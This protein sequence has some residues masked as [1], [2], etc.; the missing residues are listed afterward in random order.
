MPVRTI[1]HVI[2]VAQA[3]NGGVI[4]QAHRIIRL[5][6]Y[7]AIGCC[8]SAAA[9]RPA[10]APRNRTAIAVPART[11]NQIIAVA[12]RGALAVAHLITCVAADE[13]IGVRDD[14]ADP[15]AAVAPGHRPAITV[16]E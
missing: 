7:E 14:T 2:A 10:V 15:R 3:D 12:Q 6:A 13:A 8:Y 11:G 9:P 1:D 4:G 16:P 5:A